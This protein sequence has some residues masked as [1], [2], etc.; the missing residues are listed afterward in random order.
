MLHTLALYYTL[1]PD[2]NVATAQGV[3]ATKHGKVLRTSCFF[4]IISLYEATYLLLE[5]R[6]TLSE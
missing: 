2:L 4:M 6:P 3:I 5:Q 1:S